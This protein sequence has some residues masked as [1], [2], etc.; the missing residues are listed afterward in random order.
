[1]TTARA[2]GLSARGR[3]RRKP[4]ERAVGDDGRLLH[5]HG[6]LDHRRHRQPDHHGQAAHGYD[7]VI[8][9]TSAY[10]LAYAVPLLV[11][12]RLGDRFGPKNLYLIGLA[13]FTA[14]S[15][16]CGLS[17]SA[18]MLIT[19]RVVQGVGAGLLTPQTLSTI[20]R[21]FPAGAARR[22][23]EHVGR[24]RRRRQPGRTAG[25][26]RAGRRAGLGVDLLR[27]RARSASI[28]LALAVW[29][30]PAL[31]TQTHRFDLVGVGLSGVGMFLIVFGLQ[32][33]SGRA[34]AAV[35]LGG[36]R[37]RR[38][39]HVGVRLLAVGQHARAADPAGDLQRP[40]LQPVQRRRG[41]HRVRDHGDDAAADVLCAGGVRA[42]ADAL[43]AA[44]RA[45]GDRQRCAGA[46]RRQD[47]RPNPSAA[48]ARF[49]LL[50][51][52]DRAD[53]AFV[54]DGPRHADLAAGVAVHR[55]GCRDGV[56]VVAAGG[57][58]DPQPAAAAGRR[59]LRVCTTRPGSSARCWAAP[60][61]PRS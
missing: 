54:R 57:H 23:D 17:G 58:R 29:L 39:V 43:G 10:L 27:Q 59:E 38:R 16:W 37:R 31:P 26:R 22:R 12:G 9:V 41:G 34:L 15:V 51:A 2:P 24:H 46:V 50:G 61:W 14:A 53:L 33:G 4:L 6:R 44:D 11:A 5:D 3:A 1:M 49:R 25:R 21:I 18:G 28:G 47:R 7:T 42:V 56:R 40:R 55:D 13:V 35:D 30:V 19:A 32:A 45:D 52:G 60:A 48:G 8:W 36:D 20:T